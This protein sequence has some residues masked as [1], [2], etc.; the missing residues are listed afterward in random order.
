MVWAS[1]GDYDRWMFK[2][3]C[4]RKNVRFPLSD[5]HLNLKM[6]TAVLWGWEREY[7]IG[8][9][10]R[11]MQM[12]FADDTIHHR[13]NDDAFNIARAMVRQMERMKPPWQ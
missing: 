12:D 4:E 11:T 7:G 8:T 3:E 9:A 1:W 5:R 2:S 13:G 6:M 10:L